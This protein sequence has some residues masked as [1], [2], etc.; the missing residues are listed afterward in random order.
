MK[1][2]LQQILMTQSR[3]KSYIWGWMCSTQR[4]WGQYNQ[5]VFD[6]ITLPNYIALVTGN[7]TTA[8]YFS[9]RKDLNK[10]RWNNVNKRKFRILDDPV[11]V[12]PDEICD[13]FIDVKKDLILEADLYIE[14]YEYADRTKQHQICKCQL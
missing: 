3:L 2:W 12:T 5:N 1:A 14:L 7:V 11:L 9:K 8:L 6:F 4:F 13:Y 10:T